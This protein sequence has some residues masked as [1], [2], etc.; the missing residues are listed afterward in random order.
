MENRKLK[1]LA[2]NALLAAA[3]CVLAL[4]LP[5]ASF[6]PVQFRLSEALTLL[7]VFSLSPAVGVTLGCFLTNCVGVA[8]GVTFPQDILFGTLATLLGCLLTWALRGVRVKGLP[9]LSALAPVACNTLIIGW[10]INAFF[11]DTP[12][13]I[14]FVTSALGVG[15][16]EL[17][18]CCVLGL[19]LVALLE[20]AG[21]DSY[22]RG[23]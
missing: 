11:L 4:A 16:G 5:Q 21:L 15:L 18:A 19:L 2:A 14:G 20:R 1:R 17:A 10:E 12:S 7:P 13:A 9:V 23:L 8:M 6:G 22:F 3:Y